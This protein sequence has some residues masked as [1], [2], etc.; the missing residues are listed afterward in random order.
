MN[1]DEPI[2]IE[3]D[4]G[5]RQLKSELKHA[6]KMIKGNKAPGTDRIMTEHIKA[7][8]E[9]AVDILLDLC[10]QIYDTG[11]IPEDL[12]QSLVIRLAKK[13]K[14]M[15]CTEHRTDSLMSHMIKIMLK[16]LL[17]RN[18]KKIGNEIGEMQS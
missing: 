2:E 9:E 3:N 7:L 16:I 12:R 5:P 14:A 18:K 13:C 11:T 15:E 10:R 4:D 6:I 17:S 1:G 8:D